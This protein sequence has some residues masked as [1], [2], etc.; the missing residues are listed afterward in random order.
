MRA[1]LTG[2]AVLLATACQHAEPMTPHGSAAAGNDR[3]VVLTDT[4]GRWRHDA[5]EFHSVAV[6]GDTLHVQVQYAGGCARHD[7]TLLVSPIFLESYPVQ[8]RGSLAHHANGDMCRAL[9]G[10]TLR[11]DLTPLKQLYRQSYGVESDT[12]HLGL[13]NWSERVVYRF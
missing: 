5:F 11:F 8:M 13:G 1:L 4:P 6:R 9:V 12:I 3:P 7:F 10:S 2:A